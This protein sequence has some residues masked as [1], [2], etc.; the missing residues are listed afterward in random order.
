MRIRKAAQPNK[1]LSLIRS[2]FTHL[3]TRADLL[4]LHFGAVGSIRYFAR[5]L[6]VL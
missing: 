4:L 2:A 1:E 3:Q 6:R 5:K